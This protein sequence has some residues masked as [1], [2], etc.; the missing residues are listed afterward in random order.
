MLGEVAIWTLATHGGR[1]CGLPLVPAVTRGAWTD[2]VRV[3]TGVSAPLV[4]G[5]TTPEGLGPAAASAYPGRL[6]ADVELRSWK[7]PEIEAAE[8]LAASCPA[9]TSHGYI[10]RQ[11]REV[12][13]VFAR[14]DR[15]GLP[16]VYDTDRSTRP[17]EFLRRCV[18][19]YHDHGFRQVVP[20]LGLSA[21]PEH[22]R[23]WIEYLLRDGAPFHLYA[24][25]RLQADRRLQEIA[26]PA[27]GPSSPI[28]GPARGPSGP[29]AG[30]PI[31]GP[32]PGPEARSA[33]DETSLL[34]LI[35]LALALAYGAQR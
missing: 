8:F 23:A 3:V 25:G 20:L 27:R 17:V 1:Y 30:R 5:W 18:G 32:L 12:L 16:Q 15:V 10:P 7:G 2:R 35:A 22:V 33:R 9:V 11:L 21:G 14:R 31:P 34:P 6:V 24:L 28:P 26:C 29:R 13:G 4:W 19:S